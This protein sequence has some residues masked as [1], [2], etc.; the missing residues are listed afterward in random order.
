MGQ[1]QTTISNGV[2]EN[3]NSQTSSSKTYTTQKGQVNKYKLRPAII[4]EH[5]EPSSEIIGTVTSTKIVGQIFKPSQDNINGLIL[6]LESA[7][8]SDIDTFE[9]YADSAALQAEWAQTDANDKAE[10]ETTIVK[11]DAKSMKLKMSATVLDEW[12]NTVTSVNYT[13]FTLSLNFYQTKLYATTNM[14]FFIGDGT[15]TKSISLTM[16]SANAW[17]HFDIDENA[18]AV[19]ANDATG[20]TPTM[21]AITKIGFRL[22]K[23]SPNA[24][25]YVDD[26]VAT[27][28][29]G[30][31]S[32]KLWDMG[33]SIPV[34]AVT[35]IDDGT[36]YSELGDR[37]INGGSVAATINLQLVGGKRLYTIKD[38]VAGAALESADNTVLNVNNY[39]AI[40]INY[41]DTNV[42]VYGII[43][44]AATNFYKNG[45]AFTVADEATAITSA[46]EY[47]SC[48]FSILSTQDV[49]VNSLIKIF[50]AA[51]GSDSNE[52]IFIEDKYS[53]I[54]ILSGESLSKQ[55]IDVEFK[56]RFFHLP[57]GGI[58]E[59]Y[60]NSDIT[61][62]VTQA[63]L[64]I[65]Y[66]YVK[67]SVNG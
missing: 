46:G 32:L 33:T 55:T 65:G 23:A 1:I 6:T 53:T 21:S 42:A 41:V 18:M 31:V 61:D 24:L 16:S 60:H 8:G 30:E 47:S 37:G 3:F 66:L 27:T 36:Q 14:S 5:A 51:P 2:S 38:F 49:H 62:S 44:T 57:K 67:K 29:P 15:N 20:T 43:A 12:I 48:M 34:T 22:D 39:Y 50:N 59:V 26:I 25:A 28:A 58:F 52:S 4:N 17:Q 19:T 56:D 9:T 64:L 63:F 13:D 10:L 7:G 35:S 40:T 54:N 45:Y 11:T